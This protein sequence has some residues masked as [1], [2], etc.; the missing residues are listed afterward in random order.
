MHGVRLGHQAGGDGNQ[1]HTAA[2]E[3][4]RRGAA[5]GVRD[6]EGVGPTTR[7]ADPAKNDAV[8]DDRTDDEQQAGVE[9]PP[10]ESKEGAF[11]P[12]A[13]AAVGVNGVRGM[14]CRGWPCL[15]GRNDP[16]P[17]LA[18]SR[19]VRGP[20]GGDSERV[21]APDGVGVGAGCL[22]D[23]GE[24]SR[25][26]L[27]INRRN[28]GVG[29]TAGE[30]RWSQPNRVA[31]GPQQGEPGERELGHLRERQAKLGRRRPE[32]GACGRHAARKAR[33][34]EIGET[35]AR[36]RGGWR[37]ERK[38]QCEDEPHAI[39]GAACAAAPL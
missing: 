2:Q 7:S 22:P 1:K 38:R 23:H 19:R 36:P 5:G 37:H 11:S 15:S 17:G 35:R 34:S 32:P 12:E 6:H 27:L 16:G 4:E 24:L 14:V 20:V 9:H 18:C 29:V 39:R 10:H 28:D 25:R 31:G 8:K 21:A 13:G 26:E 33:V 30:R 3:A